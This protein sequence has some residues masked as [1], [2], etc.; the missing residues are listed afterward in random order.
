MAW[1]HSDEHTATLMKQIKQELLSDMMCLLRLQDR[2]PAAD[3]EQQQQ[4]QPD[5]QQRHQAAPQQHS[6]HAAAAEWQQDVGGACQVAGSTH[7]TRSDSSSQHRQ[8]DQ[9]VNQILLQAASAKYFKDRPLLQQLVH[10]A[11]Q[12]LHAAVAVSPYQ[13]QAQQCVQH[14]LSTLQPGQQQEGLT[15]QH[16]P[17]ECGRDSRGQAQRVGCGGTA[18]RQDALELLCKHADKLVQLEAEFR[19]S[20]Q[21][22][23]LLD[24]MPVLQTSSQ[25]ADVDAAMREYCKLRA[26]HVEPA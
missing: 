6:G 17:L 24:H 19:S 10:D 14:L 1:Q 3:N 4:K 23:S 21:W 2:Y 11:A 16:A 7:S 13:Q 15:P 26:G 5:T 18:Y 20:G 12:L 8:T 9:A 22:E 25:H